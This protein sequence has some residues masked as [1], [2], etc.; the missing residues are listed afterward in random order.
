MALWSHCYADDTHFHLKLTLDPKERV[1]RLGG[2]DD[3]F[4][5]RVNR[6]R[7]NLNKPEELL[8]GPDSA[9]E[10]GQTM[11]LDGVALFV[12]WKFSEQVLLLDK[13]VATLTR[14]LVS[15]L[16]C[17][18]RPFLVKKDRVNMCMS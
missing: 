5:L 11:R 12:V 1:E 4:L 6:L 8:V 14:S 15:W 7:V 2:R 13:H 9:L 10:S 17:Q 16:I 3:G 18:M